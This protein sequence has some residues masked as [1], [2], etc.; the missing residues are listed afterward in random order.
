MSNVSKK[1]T[2]RLEVLYPKLG[3][4]LFG[5]E[6]PL[7]H[8]SLGHL[9]ILR[10]LDEAP[11]TPGKLAQQLRLTPGAISQHLT[12]LKAANLVEDRRSPEDGRSKIVG[13][14]PEGAKVLSDRR[15][16]RVKRAQR[17]LKKVSPEEI[18]EFL[19][20]VSLII[21]ANSDE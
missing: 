3:T 13:L 14:T 2:E 5:G 7:G 15:S 18:E 11:Q 1:N 21:E 4:I 19:R 6:D 20:L 17:A 10:A 12:R 16:T 9:R 8:L